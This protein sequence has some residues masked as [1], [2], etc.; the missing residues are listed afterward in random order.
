[1]VERVEELGGPRPAGQETQSGPAGGPDEAGGQVEHAGPVGLA[2]RALEGMVRRQEGRLDRADPCRSRSRAQGFLQRLG[3]DI[4]RL[5]SRWDH[6]AWPTGPVARLGQARA[7]DRHEPLGQASTGGDL[8]A[9][10]GELGKG[11]PTRGSVFVVIGSRR[12]LPGTGE[13]S[14]D[15]PRSTPVGS[16]TCRP[17]A[18]AVRR[19]ARRPAVSVRDHRSPP[20]HALDAPIERRWPWSDGLS[21]GQTQV[22]ETYCKALYPGS[23]PG[24]ASRGAG[25][26]THLVRGRFRPNSGH[27]SRPCRAP[28]GRRPTRAHPAIR[29]TWRPPVV[30]SGDRRTREVVRPDEGPRR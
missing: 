3:E 19:P 5:H 1:M 17:C 26:S 12:V 24:V 27:R 25:L 11:D 22:R 30:P 8:G 13:R 28:S 9:G 21:P 2:R 10:G 6:L 18:M 14:L 16:A 7:A 29:P 23:I 20:S 15:R 4:R